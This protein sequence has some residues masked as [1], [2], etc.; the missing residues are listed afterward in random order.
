MSV[1]QRLYPSPE[2]EAALRVHQG[3]ARFVYNRMLHLVSHEVIRLQEMD[4]TLT[5]LRAEF[6][7]LGEGSTVVQQGAIRDL[8]RAFVNLGK[9][10]DHFGW[11]AFKKRGTPVGVR[12]RDLHVRRINRKWAQV[13]VPKVGWVKFRLT[14]PF[15][16]VQSASSARITQTPGGAWHVSF[17]TKDRPAFA[18]PAVERKV[19]GIDAGVVKTMTAHDGEKALVFQI[20]TLTG[21]EQE[22]YLRL[23]RQ[24]ARQ[25]K[26]SGRYRRTLRKMGKITDRLGNRRDNWVEQ[27][28]TALVRD[29]EVIVIEDLNVKG[30]VKAPAPKPDPDQPGQYLR[31][32][33][34]AK[35][36]LNRLIHSS[37]WAQFRARLEDKTTRAGTMLVA[38][39]PAHTSQECAECHHIAEG[40]RES[41]AVFRC[42]NCEHTDNADVNAARVLRARALH[43]DGTLK[44]T[45]GRTGR[46][47]TRKTPTGRVKTRKEAA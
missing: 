5:H 40:N 4:R 13:M 23:A 6:G 38:V 22:R 41:Q 25:Q 47:R 30:M 12:V 32:G 24:L 15:T 44:T 46:Q 45:C 36:T 7:W 35:A 26:G 37:R 29:Y 14:R 39:H 2:Q 42:L 34:A 20:P 19:V 11:P 28:T 18:R 43:P 21:A 8:S 1:K 33:A 27:T 17:T 16:D 31:N 3:Q 9:N 10:G